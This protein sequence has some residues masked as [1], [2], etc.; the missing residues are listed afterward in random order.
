MN[1]SSALTTTMLSRNSYSSQL[2]F[3]HP[4]LLRYPKIPSCPVLNNS[5][6]Y[7][8]RQIELCCCYKMSQNLEI[9]TKFGEPEGGELFAEEVVTREAKYESNGS[10]HLA[11]SS[12]F[13][14][15]LFSWKA[16]TGVTSIVCAIVGGVTQRRWEKS[17]RVGDE[18]ER[19]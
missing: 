5:S 16:R 4:L 11:D 3:F 19:G 7:Q 2:P 12:F 8:T 6:Q 18:H 15:L 13:F 10:L 14:F 9:L 1:G 17:R